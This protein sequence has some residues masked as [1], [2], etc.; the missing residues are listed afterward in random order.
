MQQSRRT[1]QSLCGGDASRLDLL[2]SCERSARGSL[3]GSPPQLKTR[4][5]LMAA[6]S[7]QRMLAALLFSL[8]NLAAVPP[9]RADSGADVKLRP[10]L[11][12]I[13]LATDLNVVGNSL[14]VCTQPGLLL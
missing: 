3:G 6:A 8:A 14:F 7:Q 9:A 1:S 13:D 2:S 5:G 12:R 10:V 4:G 11:E